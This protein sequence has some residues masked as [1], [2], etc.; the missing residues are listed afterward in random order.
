MEEL[1]V[2]ASL[3]G[4]LPDELVDLEMGRGLVHAPGRRYNHNAWQVFLGNPVE[5]TL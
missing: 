4:R 3:Y 5:I 2:A 1:G